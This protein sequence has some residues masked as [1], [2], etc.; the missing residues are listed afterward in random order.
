MLFLSS[1]LMAFAWLGH[2]KFEDAPFLLALLAAW[3][4]VLPEYI[5]NVAAVRLGKGIYSGATMAS[6]NLC[7]G[8]VCVVFVSR[9]VLNEAMSIRQYAGFALM[10]VAMLLIGSKDRTDTQPEIDPLS[11]EAER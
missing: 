10:F 1:M 7:W 6:L 11:D 3:L 4:I 2:L 8:V 9:F 5:L